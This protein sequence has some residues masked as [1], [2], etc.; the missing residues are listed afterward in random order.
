MSIVLIFTA[1]ILIICLDQ[2]LALFMKDCLSFAVI[3]VI[4]LLQKKSL[5]EYTFLQP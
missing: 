4:F 5:Q 1:Y 2:E 3:V